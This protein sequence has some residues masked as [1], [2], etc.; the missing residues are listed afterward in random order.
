MLLTIRSGSIN[1]PGMSV[2]WYNI[3]YLSPSSSGLRGRAIKGGISPS[4][5]IFSLLSLTSLSRTGSGGEWIYI[6]IYA[7]FSRCL[8]SGLDTTVSVIR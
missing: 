1:Y 8:F 2:L 7:L 4:E 5:L 3:L 6:I